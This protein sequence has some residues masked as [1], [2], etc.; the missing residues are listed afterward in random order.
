MARLALV[1]A[2]ADNCSGGWFPRLRP[3]EENFTGPYGVCGYTI[4]IRAKWE[5]RNG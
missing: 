1:A 2:L 4:L 3:G 5:P